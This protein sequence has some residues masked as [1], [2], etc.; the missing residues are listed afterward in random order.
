[1]IS[2]QSIARKVTTRMRSARLVAATVAIMPAAL[3]L[4]PVQASNPP[5]I[6][7]VLVLNARGTPRTSFHPGGKLA[8]RVELY[9]V[10]RSAAR[11]KTDWHVTSGHRVIFHRAVSGNFHGPMR[12]NLFTQTQALHLSR[13]AATGTYDANVVINVNGHRLSRTARFYVRR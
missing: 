4:T 1:M 7:Y 11:V 5:R 10:S 8:V 13:G 9:L 3:S 2:K 12:G 6:E